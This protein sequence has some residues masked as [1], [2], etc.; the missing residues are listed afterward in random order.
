[1]DSR[2]YWI[3]LQ[4]AI[5]PGSFLADALLRNFGDAAAVYHAD[6]DEVLQL[7]PEA[8]K[9]VRLQQ[10]ALVEA[11][12]ILDKTVSCGYWMMT[13]EDALFPPLLRVIQGIP[14]VLYGRG[15]MP[16]LN[17]F[18]AVTVVGTREP[19]DYGKQATALISGGL[20]AGGAIVVSGGARG[21]DAIAHSMAIEAGGITVAIQACGIDVNYPAENAHLRDL[22]CRNGAVITEFASGVSAHRH[23]FSIRNRL[24]S[25]ISLAT[26]VTESPSVSGTLITAHHAFEQG[27]DVFAVAGDM[28]TGRSAGTD[29]LIG[30]G[31]RLI[32]GAE[33][34]IAEYEPWYRGILDPDAA[35]VRGDERF[36]ILDHE[37]PPPRG[38]GKRRAPPV[39]LHPEPDNGKK[40][41]VADSTVQTVSFEAKPVKQDIPCPDSATDNAKAAYAVL[42]AEPLPVDVIIAAAGLDAKS[43]LVALTELEMLGC[44]CRHPGQAYCR[45]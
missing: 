40:L 29:S 1:M 22:I 38:R 44:A 35:F 32:R 12:E 43:A 27:R 20:A 25:G 39:L 45:A 34:I 11:K 13:P 31:A 5:G 17:S 9:A 4:Q 33:E 41:R 6:Y 36:K 14:L 23:H 8:V 37:I 26:V 3:W 7:V 15:E 21:G 2:L 30:E 28:L 19:S 18:P 24:M 16:D 10:S 42:T